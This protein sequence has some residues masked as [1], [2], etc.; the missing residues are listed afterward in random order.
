MEMK[1]KRV[2]GNAGFSM[3]EAMIAAGILLII[4]IGMIPLFTRSMLNN[5]MG[6]DYTQATA[7][8]VTELEE[9]ANKPF[10]SVDLLP[11]TGAATMQRVDYVAR[12]LQT[13]SAV[14]D[15]DW[16]YTKKDPT[17]STKTIN[18]MWTRTLRVRTFKVT[19]LDDGQLT[20]DELA[21]LTSDLGSW[22]LMEIS[23][24]LDSGKS[25]A[26]YTAGGL[27]AIRQTNF[28]LLKAF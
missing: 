2:R 7:N 19:A 15:L 14:S 9:S 8:G 6:N 13:G 28:Q 25:N 12:G 21:S 24:L 20:D 17:D 27:A 18:V 3:I 26:G 1:R 11:A 4:A 23:T 16:Q 5:A 10:Q 22:D